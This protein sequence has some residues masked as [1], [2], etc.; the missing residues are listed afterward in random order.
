MRKLVNSHTVAEAKARALHL[1]LQPV[2]APRSRRCCH[3]RLCYQ[4]LLNH[5]AFYSYTMD[6][7][8]NLIAIYWTMYG[9]PCRDRA[10]TPVNF[11]NYEDDDS[12]YTSCVDTVY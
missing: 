11:N 12:G 6:E 7:I 10:L 9:M 5:I 3:A 4:L 8:R 2:V 1:L